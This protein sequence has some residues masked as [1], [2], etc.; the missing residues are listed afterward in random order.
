MTY[1]SVL[2]NPNTYRAGRFF[3]KIGNT[4]SR[5]FHTRTIVRLTSRLTS[6]RSCHDASDIQTASWLYAHRIAYCHRPHRSARLAAASRVS[7]GKGT[8]PARQVHQQLETNFA[9][10]ENV[11]NGSRLEN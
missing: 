10:G 7:A 6:S 3:Q 5:V 8:G 9:G 2:T 1:R 11:R 4:Y